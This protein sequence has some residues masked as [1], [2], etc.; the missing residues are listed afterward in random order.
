VNVPRR[1]RDQPRR[2]LD[3][4]RLV[5]YAVAGGASAATHLGTLTLLVELARVRAV[6]A[7][8][9][10]FVLS[11]IVSYTLQRR[12]VFASTI[13]NRVAVPRF[14]VVTAVGLVLN[15]T[16]VAVGTELL[17]RHYAPVQAV[18]LVLIPLSNYLLNSLW[19]FRDRQPPPTGAP[20]DPPT[21]SPA[22]SARARRRLG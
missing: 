8:S 10:G 12:W 13:A 16:V 18:A 20:H 11:I 19:T 15:A 5:R 21:T 6:V 3:V 22:T 4:G 17:G 1:S 2:L 7:S 14:L 9:I